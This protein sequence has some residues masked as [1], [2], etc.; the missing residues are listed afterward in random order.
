MVVLVFWRGVVLVY[1]TH[2]LFLRSPEKY[3]KFF[4]KHQVKKPQQHCQGF[5]VTERFKLSSINFS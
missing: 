3:Q 5:K 2:F 4:L 1:S